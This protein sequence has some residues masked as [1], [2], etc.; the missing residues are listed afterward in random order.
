MDDIARECNYSARPYAGKKGVGMK[1]IRPVYKGEILW[2]LP[3]DNPDSDILTRKYKIGGNEDLDNMLR[4]FDCNEPTGEYILLKKQVPL[5][6]DASALTNHSKRPNAMHVPVCIQGKSYRVM[7]SLK[8]MCSDTEIFQN[9]L[10]TCW[11]GHK[12]TNDM[13]TNPEN[14][15]GYVKVNKQTHQVTMQNKQFENLLLRL[16]DKDTLKPSEEYPISF[17]FALKKLRGYSVWFFTGG[18]WEMG[19]IVSTPKTRSSKQQ[20]KINKS[21]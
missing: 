8:D 9:Y 15:D 20:K 14:F 4:D 1:T 11:E 17:P 21:N 13:K 2:F 6:F 16:D 18:Q 7:I 10:L 19:K 3:L 5:T 12:Y